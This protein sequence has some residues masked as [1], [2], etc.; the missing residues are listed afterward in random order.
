[1]ESPIRGFGLFSLQ[2][3]LEKA[4]SR[5]CIPSIHECRVVFL[6]NIYDTMTSQDIARMQVRI[7]SKSTE[8]ML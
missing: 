7:Y 1:M 3:A 2:I 5:L 6:W 8:Q 4:S